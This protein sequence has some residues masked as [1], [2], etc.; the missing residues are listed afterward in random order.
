MKRFF[1]T[2]AAVL[3][4]T[5]AL[6]LTACGPK[7]PE[8]VAFDTLETARAQ[9]RSNATF[10]ATKWRADTKLYADLNLIAKGDSTQTAACPQGD[11][12]ATFEIVDAKAQPVDSLK[13]STVSIS[14]GCRLAKDFKTSPFANEDNQC[15]PTTRVPHPLP[16]LVQ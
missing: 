11:G 9:A 7:P 13:C 14:V 10:N 8:P 1:L 3:A 2:L 4:P 6:L 15:A 5:A 16:K 12:W